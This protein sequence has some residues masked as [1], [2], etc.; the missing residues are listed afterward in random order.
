MTY[1][2]ECG[3]GRRDG[4]TLYR[5]GPKGQGGVPWYC[6]EHLPDEWPPSSE[7]VD[8]VKAITGGE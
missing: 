7:V 8:V 2:A 4:V 1:C 5:G 3:K 6:R